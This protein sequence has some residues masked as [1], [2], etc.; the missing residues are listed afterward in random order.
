MREHF[1]IHLIDTYSIEMEFINFRLII[2]TNY[3][4]QR[5]VETAWAT[6]KK[7]SPNKYGVKD[8]GAKDGGAKDCSDSLL[9][10][11]QMTA[12]LRYFIFRHIFYVCTKKI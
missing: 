10:W 1:S 4:L 3:A 5:S 8:G 9:L 2:H 11:T 6:W 12:K 7:I